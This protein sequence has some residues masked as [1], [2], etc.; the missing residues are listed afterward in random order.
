MTETPFISRRF[1]HLEDVD[2]HPLVPVARE[3][4][5]P[6]NASRP[7]P[8][9]I[10]DIDEVRNAVQG[11]ARPT[12]SGDM[13]PRL[14]IFRADYDKDSALQGRITWAEIQIR[15]LANN[16]RYL[17][18]A[19]AMEQGGELFGVDSQGNLLICDRGDEPIMTGMNYKNT[20]NRVLYRHERN[21]MINGADRNPV[22]TGYEMFPYSGDSD[23][24]SEIVQYEAHTGKPFIK[25]PNGRE[26]RSSWVESGEAPSWPRRVDYLPNLTRSY[27][28][29]VIPE[30]RNPNRGVRRLLRVRES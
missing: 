6:A 2:G 15:L 25:D 16:G 17:A 5:A 29:G 19:L 7:D 8:A 26:W 28:A 23:K 21:Q 22:S 1:S 10:A 30:L 14:A 4:V 3:K 12:E 27:V 18:L 20:R 9:A 13:D 24:S 11:Q